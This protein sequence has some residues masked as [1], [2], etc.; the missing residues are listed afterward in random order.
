MTPFAEHNHAV[1]KSVCPFVMREEYDADAGDNLYAEEDSIDFS[2]A[3]NVEQARP[4]ESNRGKKSP[5]R[6][7]NS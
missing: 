4:N 1:E 5:K 2:V 7:N 3:I 6:S